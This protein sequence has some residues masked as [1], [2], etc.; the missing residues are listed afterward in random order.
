V[1]KALEVGALEVGA[2]EVVLVLVGRKKN[3]TKKNVG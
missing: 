1:K 2:L 3:T